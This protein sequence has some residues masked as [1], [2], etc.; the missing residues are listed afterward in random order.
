[1]SDRL[2]R[3]S[4]LVNLL[5]L[6]LAAAAV[7]STASPAEAKTAPSAVQYVPK[8][9]N[10][11]FC[12]N[13]RFFIASKASGKPGTCSIVSGPIEPLGWCVAYAAK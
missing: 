5:G 13:C 9:K 2:S 8:S 3:K 12:K 11:K 7:V 4:V 10:G 6:P 1:V